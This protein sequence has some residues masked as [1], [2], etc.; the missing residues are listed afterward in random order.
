V[1]P[2][3]FFL[4]PDLLAAAA[5][6]DRVALD[7]DEGRHASDVRRIRV[8]EQI[9]LT[10]GRGNALD[11]VV[12]A[13]RRGEL[14]VEIGARRQVPPPSPRVTVVQALARG[15]RDEQAVEVMTE[16]GA[17]EFV[18]WSAERSVARWTERTGARWTAV[19]RSAAKQ[20]RRIWWPTVSG[21]ASTGDVAAVLAGTDAG[22]VLHES[23]SVPLASEVRA[24]VGSVAVVVGPEGGLTPDE[25]EALCAAGGIAV[26]LGSTVLRSSSAGAAALAVIYAR[27]RWA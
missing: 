19:A 14:A 13:V 11:G 21:P 23:A 6:G 5:E 10:D 15:G 8:G 16:L 27:T 26:R 12:A 25:V 1:T 2:P 24:D 22:Y 9:V 20:S 4:D 7:G 18:G 3:V 17:D